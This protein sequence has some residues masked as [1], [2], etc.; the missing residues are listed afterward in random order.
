MKLAVD[1]GGCIS[2][3]PEQ[4]RWLIISLGVNWEIFIITDMHDKVEV[5]K[6]L[7]DN[8]IDVLEN[9]V[10]CADYAKYGEM[11]KAVLLKELEIDMF[12]DDFIGYTMAWDSSFG[13]APIRLL[14]CPDATMP[15]WSNQWIT[16][17]KSDF[18]RRKFSQLPTPLKGT[19]LD[20]GT[21][22]IN[23]Q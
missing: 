6:Q 2:K 16:D 12:I 1:I 11:C 14:V 13:P 5:M 9:H 23:S 20:M 10:Y 7:K 17:D 21:E 3:Y 4:F 18:G 8:K 15:Y 19:D 22:L